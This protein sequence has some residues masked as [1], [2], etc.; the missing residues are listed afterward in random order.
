MVEAVTAYIALGSNV[1]SR[2]GYLTSAVDLLS[3]TPGVVIS[4]MS[5][6]IETAAVGGPDD[7]P[8]Y[9]NAVIAVR[10]TL[11]ASALHARMAEIERKLGR[12]AQRERDLPR[13][14]DL[15]LLLYGDSIVDDDGLTIPHPRMHQR[16]FVL[17]P[18]AEIAPDAM[19]PTLGK[20]VATLLRDI[21]ANA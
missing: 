12:P 21:G 15:D 2:M 17:R 19:H 20:S 5:N 4:D 9:L 7:S 3:R 8:D 11:G 13:T 16:E 10:T 6:V 18:L 1:G 14:I